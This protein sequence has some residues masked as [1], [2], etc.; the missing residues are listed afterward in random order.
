[1]S[2]NT[3]LQAIC[4]EVD[5]CLAAF[6]MSLDGISVAQ[7]KRGAT[8]DLE[9]LLIELGAPLRQVIAAL[10]A[11]EAGTLAEAVLASEKGVLLVRWLQEEY[12]VA[13]YLSPQAILGRARYVL[14]RHTGALLRELS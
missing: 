14:R 9:T 3:E 10:R 5:G 7:E 1:M 4:R 6:V 12:F 8:L 13:L 11:G 2:F